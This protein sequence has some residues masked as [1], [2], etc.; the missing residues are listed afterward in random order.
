MSAAVSSLETVTWLPFPLSEGGMKGPMRQQLIWS[1]PG[2]A[3]SLIR[4]LVL[5]ACG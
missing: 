1:V 5:M 2:F 3:A 4:T